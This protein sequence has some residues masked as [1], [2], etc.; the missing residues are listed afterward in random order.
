MTAS[1][2]GKPMMRI[3]TRFRS[4]VLLVTALALLLG[5]AAT[6][7]FADNVV[8][9]H[10]YAWGENVGWLNAQP[11][12]PGGPGLTVTS[13]DVTG[14][15][16]GENIGWVNTSCKTNFPTCTG[17]AGIWGVANDGAGNLKG[18]A[19]SEDTG[20]LDFSCHTNFPTCSGQAGTWGVKINTSTGVFSGRAWGENIGWLTFN[21]TGPPENHLETS[22]RGAALTVGGIDEQPDVTALPSVTPTSSDHTTYTLAGVI[23]L[24]AVVTLGAGGWYVRRKWAE[25]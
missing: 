20:W 11:S 25:F 21:S 19:W 18:Y 1:E 10:K 17:P 24:V 6:S 13:T 4:A 9:G 22:W 5:L 12:G 7:V 8:V 3:A 15:F 23:A 14:Y 16:W 2:N